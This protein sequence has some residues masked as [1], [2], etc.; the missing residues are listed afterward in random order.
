MENE[1]TSGTTAASSGDWRADLHRVRARRAR[2]PAASCR[3]RRCRVWRPPASWTSRSR[4][5]QY[6]PLLPRQFIDE[7]KKCGLW[8][9]EQELKAFHRVRLLVPF[10][11][12][13]RDVAKSQT[14]TAAVRT[15]TTSRTGSRR[16][17]P[18]SPTRACTAVSTTP[19]S[20]RSSRVVGS[21]A[22]S[23][24]GHTSR[25]STFTRAT[26]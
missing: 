13:A 10:Y 26:S 17:A 11:R 25:A 2:L 3:R 15:Y 5:T 9:S 21:S 22:R 4:S 7:T 23:A 19:R 14:P 24:S 18:I 8:L 6:R 12:L 20:R 1:P 16:R